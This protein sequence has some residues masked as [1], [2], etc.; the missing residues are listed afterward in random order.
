MESLFEL[1]VSLFK[2]VFNICTLT[3]GVF[4]RTDFGERYLTWSKIIVS[5]IVYSLFIK[6][7]NQTIIF[8][9][10][11]SQYIFTISLCFLVVLDFFVTCETI[12]SFHD[13]L[14]T[15]LRHH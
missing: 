11:P 1:I 2:I 14:H 13:A 9:N 5:S 6:N 7:A 10:K 12:L 8:P 4:L 15:L 3:V